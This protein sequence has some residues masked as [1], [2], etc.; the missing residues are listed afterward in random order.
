MRAKHPAA[1]AILVRCTRA[2]AF[3][4]VTAAVLGTLLLGSSAKANA[5]DLGIYGQTYAIIEPDM[6]VM[7]EKK[8]KKFV[9]SG[10]YDK[11]KKESIAR[12][13]A[14]FKEP[15]PSGTGHATVA[16]DYLFDPSV[17][18]KQDIA[19]L[20]GRVFVPKGAR[21]NP[22]DYVSLQQ[23]LYLFDGRDPAQSA[24]AAKQNRKIRGVLILTA[25]RWIDVS[26]KMGQRVFFDQAAQIANRF[27]IDGVPA[28]VTQEGKFLRVIETP[29][30]DL[31]ARSLATDD[32]DVPTKESV[33]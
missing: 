9:A 17:I 5:E 18:L 28:S 4:L 2:V 26:K 23:P 16:R 1:V 19:D 3:S 11:W 14:T 32:N 15:P 8:A 13:T 21:V 29:V 27:G 20:N 30:V 25:G 24:W 31:P 7:L 10:A 22:L 33:K 6:L 12:A